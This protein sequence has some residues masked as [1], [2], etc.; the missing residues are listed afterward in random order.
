MS[1][2]TIEEQFDAEAGI[3]QSGRISPTQQTKPTPQSSPV[4]TGQRDQTY[5][6]T[7]AAAS[8]ANDDNAAQQKQQQQ[9]WLWLKFAK[10]LASRKPKVTW[11]VQN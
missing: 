4:I 2:F 5:L 10:L 1:N 8:V 6:L 11:H 9:R 7:D 3:T